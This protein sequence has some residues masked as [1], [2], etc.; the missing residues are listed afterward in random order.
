MSTDIIAKPSAK[1]ARK[2]IIVD[3]NAEFVPMPSGR[4]S[5]K[6]ITLSRTSVYKLIESREIKTTKVR[7]AGSTQGR[8]YL[9][10]SSLESWFQTQLAAAR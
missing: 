7:V 2:T 1:R 4:L 10:R 5:Y 9:L 6:G 8:V 3:D